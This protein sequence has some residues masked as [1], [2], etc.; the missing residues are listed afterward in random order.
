MPM[1]KLLTTAIRYLQEGYSVIPVNNLKNPTVQWAQYMFKP[2]DIQVAKTLFQDVHGIALLMGGKRNLTAIDVDL[3]Y[4]ITGTLWD[5]LKKEIGKDLLEKMWVNKT[6]GGGYHLIFSCSKVEGNMKLACRATTD[7]EKIDTF[8]Y[9]I[10]KSSSAEVALK[11][12]LGDTSR[13]LI[14]TRGQ[15]GF[16]VVPPTPGYE[17][18]YGKIQEITPEEYTTLIEICYSFNEYIKPVKNYA[19]SKLERDKGKDLLAAFNQSADVVKML[20][21]HGW[22][23]VGVDGTR[24]KMKRPGN[25]TSRDSGWFDTESR[26]FWVFSTSTSFRANESYTA[27]DTILELKYGGDNSRLNELYNEL[28]QSS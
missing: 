7:K 27:V 18:I 19:L 9:E 22:S 11:S 13:V 28:K 8:N 21:D 12:G 26:L 25:V 10:E 4:D 1:S 20:E 16:I 6:V 17:Y 14:E 15:G 3:K 24:I 5:R 2:M 23:Q